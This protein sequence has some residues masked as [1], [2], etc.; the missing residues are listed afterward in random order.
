[1]NVKAY[2]KSKGYQLLRQIGKGAFATVFKAR[3]LSDQLD[4][5][6]KAIPVANLSPAQLQNCLDEVRITCRIDH[7]S[8]VKHFDSFYDA[9]A[10][11]FFIVMEYLAGGDLARHIQRMKDAR[12]RFS[13]ETI[14]RFIV[15]AFA[16]LSKLH[17]MS[18]LHRDIKPANLFLTKDFKSIKIGDLNA[19]KINKHNQL[20]RTIIGTPN[21]LAPEIWAKQGYDQRCDVFS[22]GCVIYE[23]AAL[24]PTFPGKSIDTVSSKIRQGLYKPLGSTYSKELNV[25][26]SC[27]L[28]QDFR[29]RPSVDELLKSKVVSEKLKLFPELKLDLESQQSLNWST[30]KYPS[31]LKDFKHILEDIHQKTFFRSKTDAKKKGLKI[32]TLQN[33]WGRGGDYRRSSTIQVLDSNQQRLAKFN[34]KL[35]EAPRR[36]DLYEDSDE[37]EEGF[38]G[39]RSQRCPN[40]KKTKSERKAKSDF[41]NLKPKRTKAR[42]F[43]NQLNRASRTERRTEK[44][45]L[46][47]KTSVFSNMVSNINSLITIG[48][49][50]PETKNIKSFG[51]IRASNSP[52]K[53][54]IYYNMYQRQLANSRN[55]NRRRRSP[56]SISTKPIKMQVVVDQNHDAQNYSHRRHKDERDPG[57]GQRVIGRATP[58]LGLERNAQNGKESR[59]RRQVQKKLPL[60]MLQNMNNRKEILTGPSMTRLMATD[61]KLKSEF[62]LPSP[63]DTSSPNQKPVNS[64][65]INQYHRH[66][67]S[68]TSSLCKVATG[69]T[70]RSIS[71]EPEQF[72]FWTKELERPKKYFFESEQKRICGK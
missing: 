4:V 43:D 38:F 39:N 17:Q 42:L 47:K 23:I 24:E 40:L 51:E 18:V 36:I 15:Q 53:A 28:I 11:L 65:F 21:Y 37:E 57:P 19:C 63:S 33:K 67:E 62:S 54:V 59:G 31:N 48:S 71:K 32:P 49:K 26:I 22:L 29:K 20:S 56:N 2:L 64:L 35:R 70:V 7:P 34:K 13:E 60:P 6:I 61:F 5:A 12:E 27:S 58:H 8:V 55:R 45:F 52:D 50:K 16:G 44:F 1:M 30:M 14:W 72:R 41:R 46:N 68:S 9:S 10:K 66:G 69:V 3:R 25:L